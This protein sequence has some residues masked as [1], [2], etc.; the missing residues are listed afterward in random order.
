MPKSIQQPKGRQPEG[1]AK[2]LDKDLLNSQELAASPN[3]YQQIRGRGC[4]RKKTEAPHK[5][6][7]LLPPSRNYRAPGDRCCS[8]IQ[9]ALA[10]RKKEVALRK[11]MQ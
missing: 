1:R 10:K 2:G 7:A 3:V 8:V 5:R 6:K 11:I 9:S 4:W